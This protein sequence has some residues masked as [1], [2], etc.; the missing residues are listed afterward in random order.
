MKKQIIIINNKHYKVLPAVNIQEW[1]EGLKGAKLDYYDGL[2]MIFDSERIVNITMIEM[3]CSIDILWVSSEKKIIKI[4]KDAGLFDKNGQPNS[5]KGILC[6]YVIEL[7]SGE[8]EK[9]Q[10]LVGG[11]VEF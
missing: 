10:F 7:K 2:L 11:Q 6:K 3:L 9:N 1:K 5:I 8:V 4:E